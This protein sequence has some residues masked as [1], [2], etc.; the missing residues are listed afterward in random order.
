MWKLIF[1]RV[2]S[3]ERRKGGQARGSTVQH[4]VKGVLNYYLRGSGETWWHARKTHDQL[5]PGPR[6]RIHQHTSQ[7]AGRSI[8]W[9]VLFLLSRV[10]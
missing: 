3:I 4:Y 10:D 2:D 9:L 6:T 5:L 1:L 8:N 7:S